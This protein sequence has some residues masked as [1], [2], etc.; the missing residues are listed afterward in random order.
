MR[1]AAAAGAGR[2]LGLFNTGNVDGAFD[3]KFRKGTTGKFPDQPGLVEQTRIALDTL[4]KS[5]KGFFL[6]VESARIDKY[7]HSLDWER[8]VYDTILLDNVVKVAK[9]F[10]A[11]RG[12]TLVIVVPDHAHMVGIVGT[13]DDDLPGRTPR[14]KLGV[15]GQS[16]F[17][18]YRP[19][20]D[21]YPEAVALRQRLAVVFGTYPDYCFT[22][23]PSTEEFV[24]AK[25][26]AEPQTFVAND[27]N[28]SENA[29]RITG[30]LPTMVN[31]GVHA[32]DDVIL[33][34]MGPGADA[35]RGRIDN[36]AVFRAIVT[37]LGL[38]TPQ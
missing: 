4:A 31:S 37:A 32:A 26:G 17:P 6:M 13:Y 38:A 3:Q 23:Q 30:N 2:L 29:S 10:A 5:D 11:A 25:P 1:A 34:A 14:D 24:P 8:A 22:A 9:D 18:S 35:F 20:A 12:D 7:S 27:A 21:G 33:T 19:D 16:R 28:C 36:T 15:Y